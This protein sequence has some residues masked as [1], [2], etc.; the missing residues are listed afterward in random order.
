MNC[1][2]SECNWKTQVSLFVFET[3]VQCSFTPEKL[4]VILSQLH[5]QKGAQIAL[6]ET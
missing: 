5:V 6:T 1:R 4:P 3:V 2:G